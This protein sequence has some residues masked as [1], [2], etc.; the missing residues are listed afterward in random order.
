MKKK[1]IVFVAML[2]LALSAIAYGAMMMT[3]PYDGMILSMTGRF[4]NGSTELYCP[5]GHYFWSR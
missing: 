2:L 1:I 4:R 3:C 5:N